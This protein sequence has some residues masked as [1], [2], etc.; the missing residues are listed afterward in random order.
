[1]KYDS[2]DKIPKDSCARYRPDYILDRQIHVIILEVDENQHRGYGDLCEKRRVLSLA[3]DFG[4]TPVTFVRYNPDSYKD[5][6]GVNQRFRKSREDRLISALNSLIRFPPKLEEKIRIIYLF[7]DG[8][9]GTN[10]IY[11]VEHTK[12]TNIIL[13]NETKL[14]D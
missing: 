12:N 3:Q 9:D 1:M 2:W 10:K 6:N 8:D 14:S 4:E 5:H 7:Y 13:K 11:N